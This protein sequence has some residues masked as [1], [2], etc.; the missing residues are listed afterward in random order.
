MALGQRLVTVG[1][2]L[3]QQPSGGG[4]GGGSPSLSAVAFA[5]AAA[6]P[7][8]VTALVWLAAPGPSKGASEWVGE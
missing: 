8:A 7:E 6:A 1:G 5:A 2:L 4:S 3:Q